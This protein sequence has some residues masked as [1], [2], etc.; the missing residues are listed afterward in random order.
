MATK[1]LSSPVFSTSTA[2]TVSVRGSLKEIIQSVPYGGTENAHFTPATQFTLDTESKSTEKLDAEFQPDKQARKRWGVYI[3]SG[4]S[5]TPRFENLEPVTSTTNQPFQWPS[6]DHFTRA[7]R[8]PPALM[9]TQ[10][11]L[12]QSQTMSSMRSTTS[13]FFATMNKS[14]K[15]LKR[16]TLRAAKAMVSTFSLESI[17]HDNLKLFQ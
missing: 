10:G 17:F 11:R 4:Y 7:T 9:K 6:P 15:G 13:Q 14:R 3:D 8:D 1:A 12:P 5:S 16:Q 2:D